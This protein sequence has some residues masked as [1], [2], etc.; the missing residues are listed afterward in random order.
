[1]RHY[2]CIRGRGFFRAWAC[3]YS[4]EALLPAACLSPCQASTAYSLCFYVRLG[5]VLVKCS[6]HELR[7]IVHDRWI[8]FMTAPSVSYASELQHK[9]KLHRYLHAHLA[10]EQIFWETRQSHGSYKQPR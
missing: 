9:L 5:P 6:D 8:L 1:M 4:G 10:R 3:F 2:T 7:G